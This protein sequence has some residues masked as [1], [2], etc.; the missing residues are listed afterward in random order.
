[1]EVR[2]VVGR[3]EIK[4]RRE[5]E[6]QFYVLYC[7]PTAVYNHAHVAPSPYML[8]PLTGALPSHPVV[9]FHPLNLKPCLK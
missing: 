5:R 3:E 1:M 8:S 2:Q 6:G 9:A 7:K 4:S